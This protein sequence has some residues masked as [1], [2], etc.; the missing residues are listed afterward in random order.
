[1]KSME[2]NRD[3]FSEMVN[4]ELD[5]VDPKKTM[6]RLAKAQGEY[7]WNGKPAEILPDDAVKLYVNNIVSSFREFPDNGSD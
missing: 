1:M 5:K 7:A 3:N 2:A 6:L 4:A